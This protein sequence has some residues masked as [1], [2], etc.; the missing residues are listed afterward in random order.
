MDPFLLSSFLILEGAFNPP[1]P[2]SVLLMVGF[3]VDGR[4]SPD[5]PID[6]PGLVLFGAFREDG[7]GVFGAAAPVAV[8]FLSPPPMLEVTLGTSFLTPIELFIPPLEE[9]MPPLDEFIGL[10]ASASSAAFFVEATP[11][12]EVTLPY[13]LVGTGVDAVVEAVVGLTPIDVLATP[14]AAPALALSNESTYAYRV[15]TS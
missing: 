9:F 1:V 6:V 14:L 5:V 10:D 4:E 8:G 12:L 15:L 13:F 2:E 7:A 11:S 3:D